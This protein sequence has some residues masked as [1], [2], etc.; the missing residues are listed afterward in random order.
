[1]ISDQLSGVR[2]WLL[3]GCILIAA[4]VTIGGITRL[5][6]SGLSITEWDVIMGALPPLSE[7]SWQELF[8]RYQATPQYQQVN[9]HFGLGEF[10]Q[11]FW[12]EYIHRLL[13]RTIGLVFLIPFLYFLLKRRFDRPLRNQVLVIF[14]LGAFQGVLGW[15]MVASGL[16]D[17][18]SV[19]HYRLA[20]HLLTALLTFAV[21]LWVA[22][23]LRPVPRQAAPE[24]LRKLGYLFLFLLGLQITWGAFTA[25]LKAGGMFNTFP[26]MGGEL[27]PPGIGALS[28]WWVNLT[29]NPV[30]V[31]FGHRMLAWVVLATGLLLARQLRLHRRSRE[32]L[33]L[34]AAVALQFVLGVLAIL[35]LPASPVFWGTV[36]QAGAVVLLTA[37]IL[38]LHALRGV[39]IA[40]DRLTVDDYVR[41]RSGDA[42]LIVEPTE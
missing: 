28:P 17:R 35:R 18:P 36:H 24:G 32:G 41:E 22:L 25:G 6:G 40:D 1:M 31:Q 8:A 38:A 34:G 14:A 10:K 21:T 39:A 33:L 19:S 42:R 5:T 7:A 29:Q 37:T 4:M 3:T 16:V 15:F 30:A 9:L 2:T 20:A 27:V 11:I 26:S 13:G 12:W 23:S